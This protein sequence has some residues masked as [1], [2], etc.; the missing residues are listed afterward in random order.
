MLCHPSQK[1]VLLILLFWGWQ[2]QLST[3]WRISPSRLVPALGTYWIAIVPMAHGPVQGGSRFTK[4]RQNWVPVQ[5][6][7]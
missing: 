2:M 4:Y 1:A 7:K 3:A 5:T 6:M